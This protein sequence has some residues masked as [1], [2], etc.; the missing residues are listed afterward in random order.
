MVKNIG[1]RHWVILAAM[2]LAATA[3]GA[4][5]TPVAEAQA[6]S[7]V[8]ESADEGPEFPMEFFGRTLAL[9]ELEEIEGGQRVSIAGELLSGGVRANFAFTLLDLRIEGGSV[10]CGGETHNGPFTTSI[11]RSTPGTVSIAELGSAEIK[12]NTTRT[13]FNTAE[14]APFCDEQIGTWTGIE[15]ELAGRSGFIHRVRVGET[16]TVT[17]S[18]EELVIG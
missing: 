10:S 8:A 13:V 14:G 17:L 3:C 6:N 18:L 16:E 2:C 12:L 11:V 9:E 1:N 7:T 5:S 4:D 15:G